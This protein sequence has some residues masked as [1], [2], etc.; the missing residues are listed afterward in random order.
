MFNNSLRDQ[1][2]KAIQDKKIVIKHFKGESLWR[3]KFNHW[4]KITKNVKQTLDIMYGPSGTTK[5]YRGS[6]YNN[7]NYNLKK[8]LKKIKN[9]SAEKPSNSR[10]G[11]FKF[12]RRGRP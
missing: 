11:V 7:S 6:L 5:D 12:I 1:L 8:V 10:S 4:H 3:K 2:R 9:G